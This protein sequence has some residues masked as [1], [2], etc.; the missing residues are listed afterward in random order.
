[1]LAILFSASVLFAVQIWYN[2]GHHLDDSQRS[3]VQ[4]Q[5][6]KHDLSSMKILYC[7]ASASLFERLDV[8]ERLLYNSLDW[9]EAGHQISVI[10]DTFDEVESDEMSKLL[11]DKVICSKSSMPVRVLSHPLYNERGE[12]NNLVTYHRGHFAHAGNF[13]IFVF[14]KS[15]TQL[16][17]YLDQNSTSVFIMFSAILGEDDMSIKL[18]TINRWWIETQRLKTFSN[19]YAVGTIRYENALMLLRNEKARARIRKIAA[20]NNNS[21]LLY[22][23]AEGATH[24]SKGKAMVSSLNRVT[25]EFSLNDLQLVSSRDHKS[26]WQ[27]GIP[28]KHFVSTSRTVVPPYSAVTILT[29]QQLVHLESK[30]QYLSNH[31]AYKLFPTDTTLLRPFYVSSQIF[32]CG[33]LES[34]S[35][36][37][38]YDTYSPEFYCCMHWVLPVSDYHALFIHHIGTP[39]ENAE[40]K[41]ANRHRIGNAASLDMW[42]AKMKHIS[43]GIT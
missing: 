7:I 13:D 36:S 4:L 39:G 34:V 29:R 20:M 35:H 37:G 33:N 19:S 5:N 21:A 17:H 24:A 38:I 26:V 14:G 41:W 27:P 32:Q 6:Y 3:T 2:W 31:T 30:C 43:S 11:S 8:V 40:L 22:G 10:I 42:R 15:V 28:D 23:Y 1:V 25:W 9:C 12:P 16:L 18:S